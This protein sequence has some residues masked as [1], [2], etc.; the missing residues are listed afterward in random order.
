MEH[1]TESGRICYAV[2]YDRPEFNMPDLLDKGALALKQLILAARTFLPL[3]D[4]ACVRHGI[5]FGKEE[6]K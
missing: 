1:E 4:A 6:Q 5:T 2:Q 3:Y